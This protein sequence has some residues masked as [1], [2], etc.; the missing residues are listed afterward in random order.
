V[1]GIW[2]SL[3]VFTFLD[4]KE[5][6]LMPL[7]ESKALVSKHFWGVFVR[8]GILYILF[9]I[10]SIVLAFAAQEYSILSILN[11]IFSIVIGPFAISYM[12]EIY[13]N[14]SATHTDKVQASKIWIVISIIGYVLLALLIAGFAQ[15]A[16]KNFDDN[17]IK[18]IM[19]KQMM[20]N[21]ID[22]I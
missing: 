10:V 8:V 11:F 13:K 15:S 22:S 4:K 20:Q 18:D 12:Y 5:K 21:K 7:W 17:Q 6:G 16:M 19:Q 14:V 9:W 3:S 2:G 1:W